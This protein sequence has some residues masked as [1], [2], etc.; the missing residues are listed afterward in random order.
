MI[1]A[2]NRPRVGLL[3]GEPTLHPQFITILAYLLARGLHVRVFTN[4]LCGDDLI[5]R[6]DA[7]PDPT[8]LTFLG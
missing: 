7:I 6:I 2:A 4:G 8:L 1:V 3:G 5:R